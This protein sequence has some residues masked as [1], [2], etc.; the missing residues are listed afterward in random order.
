MP[1]H[2]FKKVVDECAALGVRNIALHSIG[3]PLLHKCLPTMIQYVHD[4]GIHVFI[5][6]NGQLLDTKKTEALLAVPLDVI[7]FSIDADEPGV[8]ESIRRG[9]SFSLVEKNLADFKRL[10]DRKRS[11]TRIIITAIAF[12]RSLAF[13]KRFHERFR[14]FSDGIYFTNISNPGGMIDGVEIAKDYQTPSNAPCRLLWRT[15][16]VNWDGTV[17][18]CCLDFESV[19]TVGDIAHQSLSSIWSGDEYNRYRHFHR[20]GA[21]DQMQLCGNCTK[22][23]NSNWNL[24]K[25]NTKG[26]IAG[27]LTNFS[28]QT[29]E[30]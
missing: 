2:T 5:S 10:R 14:A 20:I 28:R 19:L 21:L 16:V 1:M 18:V 26:A 11:S 15:M 8:Y 4:A 22:D 9:G 23:V 13:M 29:N 12:D 7:R 17:T 27:V 30:E 24:L 3:E 6:T 25:L